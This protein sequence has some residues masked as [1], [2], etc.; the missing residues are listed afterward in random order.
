MVNARTLKAGSARLL[1]AAIAMVLAACAVG[2]NYSQP[3]VNAPDAFVETN[4]SLF[5]HNEVERA[6][7]TKFNDATLTQLIEDALASNHDLRIASSRL[8]Q[9]RALRGDSRF[10][11]APTV[12][13]SGSRTESRL[14]ERQAPPGSSIPRDQDYYDAGFDAAWE[15][16]LFG[17]TR[18]GIE[19]RNAEVGAAL[20]ELQNAQVSVTAEV[21]RNYFELR[22]FQH[23]LEV[24]HRNADNQRQTLQITSDRLDAGRGTELDTSRARA[25]LNSTL[26]TI[27]DLEA[28]VTRSILRL[29]VL[30]G[31]SPEALLAQLSQPKSL[32]PLPVTQSIGNPED[33]LRR[34]PDVR[35]AERQ[36][37][38]A[39]ARIGV[40]VGDLFPRVSF[41]GRWG[42]D[43]AERSDLGDSGSETYAFG[44][45]ISWGIFDLGHLHQRIRQREAATDAALA[46]YEQS[47]L[48]ALEETD[49]SLTN[50]AKALVKEQHVR[51][52]ADASTQ[53]ARLARA[54]Y[55]SGVADFLTVLDAERTALE[56]EDRLARSETQTATALLA[57]YKALGGGYEDV[58][59]A[60]R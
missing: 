56:S 9:A 50:Y 32:A 6:Y 26:S 48:Q 22:G 27:P 29:G 21:A 46:R 31:R 17:R 5:N 35:I 33:L 37:A 15:L 54:R 57:V 51:E 14:S 44:P 25:Q 53:A 2:P 12:G 20:A 24:A 8:R 45:S 43:A 18:R 30:T 36:L 58:K 60:Q 28:A 23:Q 34:R 55:D 41:V 16:D 3:K 40:A 7:W 38:A 39:T 49:A 1:P 47:V 42:F 19:A 59:T 11:L 52:S 4:S 10:D 13:V